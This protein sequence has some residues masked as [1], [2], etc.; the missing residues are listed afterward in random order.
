MRAVPDERNE[1]ERIGDVDEQ[2][3]AC[4][5]LGQDAGERRAEGVPGEENQ[6]GED[7][8]GDGV[9][10]AKEGRE[11]KE[12][13]GEEGPPEGDGVAAGGGELAELQACKHGD[14]RGEEGDHP[15]LA[16]EEEHAYEDDEDDCG[17]DS[18]H[19]F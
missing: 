9:L 8:C 11:E 19:A 4:G 3:R 13:D 2:E 14:Q 15:E 16:E 1:R 17:K 10:R 5:G 7:D 18:L 6:R 12:G